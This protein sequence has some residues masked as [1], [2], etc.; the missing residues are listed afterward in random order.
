MQSSNYNIQKRFLFPV[1]LKPLG[2]SGHVPVTTI[3][4]KNEELG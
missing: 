3:C 2:K 4:G 1:A